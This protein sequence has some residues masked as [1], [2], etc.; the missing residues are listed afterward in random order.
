MEKTKGWNKWYHKEIINSLISNIPG[1]LK[2]FYYLID[3]QSGEEICPHPHNHVVWI[4]QGWRTVATNLSKRD[5]RQC[6][7]TRSSTNIVE[8]GW[9]FKVEKSTLCKLARL[10]FPFCFVLQTIRLSSETS[11]VL[12]KWKYPGQKQAEQRVQIWERQISG[13]W[14]YYI[15]TLFVI[16]RSNKT[17]KEN[18]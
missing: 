3:K 15:Y 17:P 5:G 12:K 16:P 8:L 18:K 1:I 14:I 11:E 9:E 10:R 13:L 2:V 7:I 4:L 6:L